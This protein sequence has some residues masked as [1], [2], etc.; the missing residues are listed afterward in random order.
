LEGIFWG[1]QSQQRQDPVHHISAV[2][3]FD[4]FFGKKLKALEVSQ[5]G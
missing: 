1:L 2:L 4:Y 5:T 3:L